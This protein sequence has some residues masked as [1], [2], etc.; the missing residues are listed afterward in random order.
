M[1]L[2]CPPWDWHG[3]WRCCRVHP[4]TS[5]EPDIAVVF[6]LRP[7]WNLTLL[8]CSPW[9]WHRTWRCCRI[10]PETNMEPD[11]AVVF[12][13]R[14][15][16]NLTLL[17]CSPWDWHGTWRCCLAALPRRQRRARTSPRHRQTAATQRLPVTTEWNRFRLTWTSPRYMRQVRY[18][19]KSYWKVFLRGSE[20]VDWDPIDLRQFQ[21][22]LIIMAYN[23]KKVGA[24]FGCHITFCVQV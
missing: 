6:T 24:K 22:L 5:M 8:S 21:S 18:T 9:D 14:R 19:K 1:L 2:S 23:N 12:T 13:L 7:A 10:H 15:A 11:V 20:G 17:S 4:E 3:I 16:W